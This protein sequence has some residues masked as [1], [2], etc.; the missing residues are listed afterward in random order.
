MS[1]TIEEV[2]ENAEYNEKNAF[3]P[4]QL[5]LAKRQRS[6]YEIAK[7]L[8]ANDEDDWNEWAEKVESFKE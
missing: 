7:K 1:I 5:D 8:G 2:L 4:V 3:H 6:N